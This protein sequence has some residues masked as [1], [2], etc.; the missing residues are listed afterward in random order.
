MRA[1]RRAGPRRPRLRWRMKS[2]LLMAVALLPHAAVLWASPSPVKLIIDTDIG[3]GGCNDVDDV[4]AIC[5]ANAL[6][7]NGE[8]ELL[9]MVQNTCSRPLLTKAPPEG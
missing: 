6:A 4:G 7:D 1:A 9:A 8:A 3:G 5:I 2:F